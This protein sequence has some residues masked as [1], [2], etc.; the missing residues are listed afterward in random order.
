MKKLHSFI[1]TL[2]AI[3][4]IFTMFS[5][6]SIVSAEEVPDVWNGEAATEFA[7]GDGTETN[8]FLIENGAQLAK[9]VTDKGLVN[10]NGAIAYYMIINDIYLNED[11][12]N[13]L[14]WGTE[15]P[16]NDWNIVKTTA[17]FAGHLD[18]GYHTIY[19]M[20]YSGGGTMGA[21]IPY[22]SSN[23]TISN[24]I[25]T[26]SYSKTVDCAS[27]FAARLDNATISNCIARDSYIYG[28]TIGGIVGWASSATEGASKIENCAAYGITFTTS[29]SGAVAGGILGKS[30]NAKNKN[31]YVR[32]CFSGG[33]FIFGNESYIKIKIDDADGSRCYTDTGSSTK[34][35]LLVRT[36]LETY[37][38]TGPD[39]VTKGMPRLVESGGWKATDGYPTLAGNGVKGET[40][41]GGKAAVFAGGKGTQA[42]PFLIE[43]GEQLYKAICDLGEHAEKAA[44]Y[45]ITADIYLNKDYANYL[46]WGTN[47]PTYNWGRAYSAS[48]FT[49]NLDGG[50]HTIYGMYYS[51]GGSYA[52][53]V[54]YLSGDGAKICNLT[55]ANSYVENTAG[56]TT[57]VFAGRLDNGT[58]E[59]CIA[60]DSYLTNSENHTMA[61]IAAWSNTSTSKITSCAA[62]GLTFSSGATYIGGILSKSN[63]GNA[64]ISRCF[65]GGTHIF[66]RINTGSNQYPYI[67]CNNSYTD[68]DDEWKNGVTEILDGSMQGANALTT[69]PNLAAG[70]WKATEGYPTFAQYNGD[71]GEVWTG[72]K[73]VRYNG[74]SGTKADPYIIETAEQ[75]YKAISDLGKDSSGNA[76][77]YLVTADIYLN[78]DYDNYADWATTA[79]ANNWLPARGNFIGHLDGGLNTIYGLYSVTGSWRNGLI[80]YINSGATASNLIIAKAYI[81][82]NDNTV[83]GITGAMYDNTKIENCLVYDAV[84]SS[85]G[86]D[87]GGIVGAVAKNTTT[88]SNCGTY[89]LTM[90]GTACVG[91]ILGRPWQST[92]GANGTRVY[93]CYSIGNYPLGFVDNS[94]CNYVYTDVSGAK[95]SITT[96]TGDKMQGSVAESTMK[97]FDFINTWE[98]VENGYPVL[99]KLV[100]NNLSHEITGSYSVV[101]SGK[102]GVKFTANI[103][104]PEINPTYSN[105]IVITVN[106]EKKTVSE[107][108]IIIS[109]D[110]IEVT[111]IATVE[112]NPLTGYKIAAYTNGGENIGITIGGGY[113]TTSAIVSGY[114]NYTAKSY[115]VFADGTVV[116][117]DVFT[118]APSTA[119]TTVDGIKVNDAR[120]NGDANFDGKINIIDIIRMK[121]YA[122][123]GEEFTAKSAILDIIDTDGDN[124]FNS[125]DLVD[126]RK[127]LLYA[128]N[129]VPFEGMNLVFEDEFNTSSLDS[130][131]WDFTDYMVGYGVDTVKTSDVQSIAADEDGNGYLHLTSYKAEDGSYKATKSIS[132]GNKLTF[133]HGYVEIRAKVPTVQGA[134]PSFWLKSNTKNANLGWN[135]DALYNTEV[136]VIEVMGGN[137]VKS[138]MHKWY[139]DKEAG[140][141][142]DIRYSESTLGK[143][144]YNT[145]ELTDNDWHTYGMLWTEDSIIMYVDGVKIQEYSLTVDYE[146][147]NGLGMDGF[148]TEPL[149]I[150][151]NNYLFTPEYFGEGSWAEDYVLDPNTF[152]ESVYDID[153]V[154]LY[155]DNTGVLYTAN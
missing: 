33:K 90:S 64:T 94:W 44:Y 152:T 92:S 100:K 121:K 125:I 95:A 86:T 102:A 115:I 14:N 72:A 11:Y 146:L 113:I 150:T 57:A 74:G 28:K 46:N 108:G 29:G 151:F 87:N 25:I 37:P 141:T 148:N 43:T 130:T 75:L 120:M 63:G 45:L 32:Y 7:G 101:D 67:S 124:D 55:I 35:G 123:A 117:S 60:R 122:V 77:Y 6:I 80:P 126:L 149:C 17:A 91:G 142:T 98:T 134:W 76:A 137:E 71:K 66:A 78:K 109:R 127:T 27:L 110:G 85:A 143:L 56:N 93:N 135:S 112:N 89:N 119:A 41:C 65:S 147:L 128:T 111:D 13:Y 3:S 51:K 61:G 2:L 21:L 15:A 26:N 42:D 82:D 18:G 79:P 23:G 144:N 131:K 107:A 105:N 9:A 10:G 12:E 54:A 1:A 24:L 47:A 88:I 81:R 132:T 97:Y 36:D 140:V 40:W 50:Y 68:V 38:M 59:N 106:G 52:G 30:W 99:R 103:V 129:E 84:I 34:N 49:G 58:I 145:Y 69:M 139:T 104:M 154:R 39:A 133:I 136:D 20:Y 31:A 62:Y 73:A 96:V 70:I 138:E 5:G 83:G 114:T 16:K 53:L 4:M 116:L 118:E 8:P 155:Q 22:L 48:S 19:G 153:Y